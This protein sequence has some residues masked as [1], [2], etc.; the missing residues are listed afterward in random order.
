MAI[1]KSRYD[2]NWEVFFMNKLGIDI[3]SRFVKIAYYCKDDLILKR[4]DTIQF[5]RDCVKKNNGEM[6]V[7]LDKYVDNFYNKEIVATGYGRNVMS[8][9]N[10]KIISE[11]K[12][13]FK[14]ALNQMNK[15]NFTLIDIG[16]QDS[17]VIC[18]KNGYIEDFVMNDKCAASTGRFLENAANILGITLEELSAEVKNPVKLNS[19]CAIFSESEIIGKLAEGYKISDI[20]AGINESIARRIFPM[21]KRFKNQ[22]YYASGGVA[23]FYGIIFFLERFLDNKI[24]LVKNAQYNGAIGCLF[25]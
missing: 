23:S 6:V 3:G 7:N 10:A 12:A 13:H 1:C 22:I 25:Y 16:G 15:D 5:Y 18:V 14:G 8:F 4:I 11:I 9:R 24:V 17:K 19:T 2:F 20:A 21:I